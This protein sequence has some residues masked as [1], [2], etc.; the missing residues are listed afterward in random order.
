MRLRRRR[1][2]R[3]SRFRPHDLQQHARSS[4]AP[5]HLQLSSEVLDPRP[6]QPPVARYPCCSLS[7]TE[8]QPQQLLSLPG[9]TSRGTRK[10][11]KRL[12]YLKEVQTLQRH[13]PNV[14]RPKTAAQTSVSAAGQGGGRGDDG[15]AVNAGPRR[16]HAGEEEHRAGGRRHRHPRASGPQL[17]TLAKLLI[18]A[19]VRPRCVLDH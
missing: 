1:D 6:P 13:R 14:L 5:A 15:G 3:G 10:M 9:N 12:R 19:D 7:P 4:R 11:E 2:P 8:T 18:E 17:H 16:R